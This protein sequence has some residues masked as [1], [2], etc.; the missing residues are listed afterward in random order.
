M[1]QLQ[2]KHTHHK[3]WAHMCPGVSVKIATSMRTLAGKNQNT[4]RSATKTCKRPLATGKQK[5]PV[6]APAAKRAE[7]LRKCE[8]KKLR[9][10]SAKQH[11]IGEKVNKTIS[12]KN[13]S[14]SKTKNPSAKF[15]KVPWTQTRPKQTSN[16]AQVRRENAFKEPHSAQGHKRY[17]PQV[18]TSKTLSIKLVPNSKLR[19][20]NP[21]DHFTNIEHRLNP[22][23]SGG[24]NYEEFFGKIKV[25]QKEQ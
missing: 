19:P 13:Q 2:R 22:G 23:E 7:K 21:P 6:S 15:T 11:E 14:Q 25:Q 1:M 24:K 16:I 20:K 8:N 3:P 10:A 12:G 18:N 4:R 5:T 9:Y 17:K